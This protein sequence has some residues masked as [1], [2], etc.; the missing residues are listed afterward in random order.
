MVEAFVGDSPVDPARQCVTNA[1][2]PII[3]LETVKPRL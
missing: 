1:E 2:A 3:M